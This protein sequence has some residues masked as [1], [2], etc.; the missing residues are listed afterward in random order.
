[1]GGDLDHVDAATA[2][3]ALAWWLESGVDAPVQ[4]LPRDWLKQASAPAPVEKASE[5]SARLVA[6]A[7]ADLPETLD[8]F[9]DWLR[10]EPAL[11]FATPSAR[12][13]MPVGNA[14]A[15]IM[16]L[17]DSPGVEGLAD[18]RP[19]GGDPWILAQR[20][21]AAIGIDPEAAYCASFSC[22]HSAGAGLKGPDLQACADIARRHVALAQPKRLLL[23]GD[24]P[25]KA[26]LGKPLAAARGHIHKVESV[27]TVATFHP[28]MM[29]KYP[30]NK[31]LAW[32]DLLLLVEEDS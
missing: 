8:L 12:R 27:R 1:M 7:P 19:L 31:E 22:F 11:P 3:S 10:D 5:A 25:A 16:L 32:A 23:L 2:A 14:N 18:G 17:T 29:M 24:I 26:L 6:K 13:V 21:L 15:E 4:E 28:A 9:R 30:S 20:M